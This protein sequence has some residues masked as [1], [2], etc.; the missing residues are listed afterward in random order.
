[1]KK[2]IISLAVVFII[3][4]FGVFVEAKSGSKVLLIPREGSSPLEASQ[5]ETSLTEEV[6]VMVSMLKEEGFEV[7]VASASGQPLV[8]SST[9]LVPDLKTAHVKM[10][11][12]VGVI[13][14]C[15]VAGRVIDSPSVD[16]GSVKIVKQALTEG[17]PVAAQCGSITV[18]A[19]AGVLIGKRYTCITDPYKFF[20]DARF[21]G[22][23]RSEGLVV[24]DGNII[25][26]LYSQS[27]QGH[28]R[29]CQSTFF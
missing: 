7:V 20:G 13:L 23:I 27:R 12:Y 19:E 2:S 14:P 18:L 29:P 16:P 17:K 6:G 3:G 5:L 26:V 28:S 11:E 22:A 1:M 24:K 10:G 8:G 21:K 25:T 15:M 4:L 9:T